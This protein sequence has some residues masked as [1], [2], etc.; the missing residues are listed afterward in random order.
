MAAQVVAIEECRSRKRR[1]KRAIEERES[2]YVMRQLR[3]HQ[4]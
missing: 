3:E 4:G 1:R 2:E